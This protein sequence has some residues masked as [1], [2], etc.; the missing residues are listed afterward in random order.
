MGRHEDLEKLILEESDL[1]HEYEKQLIYE[2]DPGV[3]RNLENNIEERKNSIKKHREEQRNLSSASPAQS[4]PVTSELKQ[5]K[6]ARRSV[7]L[8]S[9]ALS[10]VLVFGAGTDNNSS[11]LL[12]A[13]AVILAASQL[14]KLWSGRS[15]QETNASPS[16]EWSSSAMCLGGASDFVFAGNFS[17]SFLWD[18]CVVWISI[19][20]YIISLLK[21]RW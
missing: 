15:I 14:V 7:L 11:F 18:D 6:V 10:L 1:L 2:K 17:D 9:T 16:I 21:K 4:E 13:I 8:A 3:K 5:W 20:I 12:L 19:I